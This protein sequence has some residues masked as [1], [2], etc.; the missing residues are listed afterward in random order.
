M[1]RE[2]VRLVELCDANYLAFEKEQG[3]P[4]GGLMG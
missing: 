1:V 3:I 2:R 4:G